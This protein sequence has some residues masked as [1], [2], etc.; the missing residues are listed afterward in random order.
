MNERPA[1][2]SELCDGYDPGPVTDAQIAWIRK[3]V[4]EI[5][6]AGI[7]TSSLL[8]EVER[9]EKSADEPR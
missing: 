9:P 5:P 2:T 7:V 8:L 6:G 3:L 4:G 1:D